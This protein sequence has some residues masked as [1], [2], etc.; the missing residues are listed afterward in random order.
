VTSSTLLAK[1]A[2]FD[3]GLCAEIK[4]VAANTNTIEDVTFRII[5]L[6]ESLAAGHSA[7]GNRAMLEEWRRR[8]NDETVSVARIWRRRGRARL[9][10]DKSRRQKGIPFR[11]HSS[12]GLRAR[13]RLRPSR[14]R[15]TR[16]CSVL[17]QFLKRCGATAS[18]APLARSHY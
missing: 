11:R 7:R 2:L 14:L 9:V 16:N 12:D 1:N 8:I 5:C 18:G 6:L 10:G 4:V 15:L 13:L 17:R 3:A